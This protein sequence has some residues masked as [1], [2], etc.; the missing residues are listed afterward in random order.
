M[1][2]LL[3]GGTAEDDE[4][5]A[6]REKAVELEMDLLGLVGEGRGVF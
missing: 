2:G 5:F 3:N 4:S 1:V 6:W